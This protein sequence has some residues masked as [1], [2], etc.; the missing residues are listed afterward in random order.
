MTE[1]YVG[2]SENKKKQKLNS[3]QDFRFRRKCLPTCLHDEYFNRF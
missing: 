2:M 3:V 1:N